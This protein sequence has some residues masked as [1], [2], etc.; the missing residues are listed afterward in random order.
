[1]ATIQVILAGQLRTTIH[2]TFD[3]P[4]VLQ[5][6]NKT[7]YDEAEWV[8]PSYPRHIPAH[9]LSEIRVQE[10]NVSVLVDGPEGFRHGPFPFTWVRSYYPRGHHCAFVQVEPGQ[11]TQMNG[12]ALTTH[13]GTLFIETLPLEKEKPAEKP[14]VE[15]PPAPT[16]EDG[17]S[18]QVPE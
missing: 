5:F 3:Y 10:G 9:R 8:I 12:V 16:L 14:P 7:S 13:D 2:D 1:M 6:N 4:I 18:D 11:Y 17:Q 15:A